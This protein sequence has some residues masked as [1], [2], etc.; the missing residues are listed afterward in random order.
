MFSCLILQ[1]L[2][3]LSDEKLAKWIKSPAFKWFL[4]FSE[5][6]PKKST[7]HSFRDKI[8]DNNLTIDLWKVHIDQILKSGYF[9]FK[10][11]NIYAQDAQFITCNQGNLSK[12]RGLKAKTGRSRTGTSARKGNK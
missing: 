4:D 3:D 1:T 5:K 9:T 6:Y 8:A 7:I 11:F 12:L 10:D 2:H